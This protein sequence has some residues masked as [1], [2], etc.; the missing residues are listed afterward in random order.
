MILGCSPRDWFTAS[1]LLL[2]PFPSGEGGIFFHLFTPEYLLAAVIA[3][4]LNPS[5][6]ADVDGSSCD[7]KVFG[8]AG[9]SVIDQPPKPL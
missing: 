8:P 5:K 2:P 4:F 9:L 7:R 6:S 1:N 3:V